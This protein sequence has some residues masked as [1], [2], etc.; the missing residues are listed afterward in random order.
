MWDTNN[1]KKH[2]ALIKFHAPTDLKQKAQQLAEQ[3]NISL[4]ALLRLVLTDYL[5]DKA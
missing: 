3:R 5:R 2:D 4:A 1:K